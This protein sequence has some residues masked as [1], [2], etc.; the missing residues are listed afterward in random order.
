MQNQNGVAQSKA[1]IFVVVLVVV[2]AGILLIGQ[3]ESATNK[4]T[5]KNASALN[6]L[7]VALARA[8]KIIHERAVNEGVDL[9]SANIVIGDIVMGTFNGYIP[10]KR[11]DIKNALGY[12]YNGKQSITPATVNWQFQVLGLSK[13]GIEQIKIFEPTIKKD[14]CYLIYSQAGTERQSSKPVSSIIDSGC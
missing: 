2:I 7:K 1:L 9:G 11:K 14:N 10:S 8:N 6:S 12:V 13:E 5:Q 3:N 4:V